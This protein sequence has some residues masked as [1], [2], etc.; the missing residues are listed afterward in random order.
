[1]SSKS[2]SK[3][4]LTAGAVIVALSGFVPDATNNVAL[5]DTASIA[6]SGVFTDGLTLSAGTKN[7]LFNTMVATGTTGSLQLTPA[8]GTA[9]VSGVFVGISQQPGTFAF[10]AAI[11]TNVNVT[12]IS[13]ITSNVA[14]ATQGKITLK[15]IDLTGP[16]AANFTAN[17]ATTALIAAKAADINV[18]GT[19]SWDTAVPIGTFSLP[20][21]ISVSY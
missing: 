15:T 7:L 4:K 13:G 6:G 5:A 19:V 1:M 17:K 18:G 3:S 21:K 16:F 2:L 8:G 9:K 14:L 10:N 11:S 20:V 12:L